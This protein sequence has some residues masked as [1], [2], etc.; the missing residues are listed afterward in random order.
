LRAEIAAFAAEEAG[1]T[2]A[3]WSLQ[4]DSAVGG[5]HR[6]GLAALASAAK[7]A[8]REL[9]A[10]GVSAGMPRSVAFNVQGFRV[11]VSP[12]TGEIRILRS[13][14]AADAGTVINPMQ[15]RGQIEGGVAQSL[16]ATLYEEAVVGPD[17]RIVNP[18]LRNYHVPTFADVP[19]TE[20]FFA[21]T[22]DRLGPF[23]A[24]S[25]SESPYNPVAAALANAVADATGIRFTA[26]PLRADRIFPALWEKFGAAATSGDGQCA[27]QGAPAIAP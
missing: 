18:S 15:C 5:G 21:E 19:R 22:S 11:A 13:L 12:Y 23:G 4:A 8:G 6:V 1:G 10:T 16:G 7:A 3:M 14:H 17:G 25:M 24:K 26:L 20:V 27:D 2:A 9:T